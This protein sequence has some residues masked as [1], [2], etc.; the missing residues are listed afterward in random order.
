MK[1]SFYIGIIFSLFSTYCYSQSFDIDEKYRGKPFFSKIDM[2][3]LEQDCTF[4]LNYPE[5]DYSKQ[6]EVNKR[7]P[8][9][10]NFSNYF[11]HVYDLVDKKTVIYQKDD[12]RLELNKENYRYKEDVNEYYNGN[13][14][15][16]VK[17]ILSL[18]KNNEIKDKITLA[19][20]F[21]NETTLLS[22]GNQYYY[23]VPSGDIYTLSLI[24]MDDGIFPQI[25]MHYKIDEKKSKFNLV[26]IYHR[27]YQITY[28]DSLTILPNPDKDENYKKSEF[29]RCLKDPYKE[30]CSLKYVEDVYRYYLQQL[31]QKTGQLS[32]KANA[33]KNLFTP[34]KKKRDKLCLDKN[35][36]LGNGYL[37]PYLD[38][39]ELVLCEI[40]QLKQDI[41]SVKK[42]LAK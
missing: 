33:T 12:L 29:D 25:W 39:N 13:E 11:D 22:V 8:L 38:Y 19:N 1:Y 30:D 17:L 40:K 35:A 24:E 9:Y 26:Q 36:L 32:Q 14:Y 34:L 41:N 20:G 28:P 31:K 7:C 42:E 23:I 18:I 16:G 15:S 6:V 37:F 2:Q 3:K 4:P 21:T 10:Y 27:G 5:L